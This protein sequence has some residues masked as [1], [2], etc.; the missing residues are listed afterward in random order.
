MA[1][2]LQ[3]DS[4]QFQ[5]LMQVHTSLAKDMETLGLKNGKKLD[6]KE[7]KKLQHIMMQT[8]AVYREILTQEQ[9]ARYISMRSRSKPKR[10]PDD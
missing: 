6:G 2:S 4:V 8:E 1:D 3:L 9:Y 5:Q 10:K 7:Q